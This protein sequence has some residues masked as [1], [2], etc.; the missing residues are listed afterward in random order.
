MGWKNSRIELQGTKPCCFVVK[1]GEVNYIGS[2]AMV[3]RNE[4][5]FTF[6]NLGSLIPIL[7]QSFVF[8]LHEDQV[9]FLVILG[10]ENGK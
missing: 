9:F 1:L 4:Y 3:K 10:K 6:F 8:P 5:G 7:D 2:S